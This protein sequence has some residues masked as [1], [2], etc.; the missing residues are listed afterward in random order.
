MQKQSLVRAMA[1]AVGIGAGTVVFA[2]E[3]ARPVPPPPEGQPA[4]P[5]KAQAG[6][7]EAFA[8]KAAAG[9]QAEVELAALAQQKTSNDQVKMLAQRIATDH[10]KANDELMSITKTRRIDID[11]KPTAEQAAMKAK[12]EKLSGAQF[13][14]AYV[15]Q[16]EKDHQKTIKEFERQAT[17]GVDPQLKAFASKVLPDLKAHLKMTMNAK[18]ALTSTSQ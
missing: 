16:M 9:G 1:F 6:T 14:R 18:R 5:D 13:D 2:Q 10:K 7:D 12:L 11:P 8:R 3:P 4:V 17:M 15:D